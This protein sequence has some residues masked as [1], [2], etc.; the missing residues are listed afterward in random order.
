MGRKTV[1]KNSNRDK[2]IGQNMLKYRTAAGLSQAKVADYIGVERSSY[3]KYEAG[4]TEPNYETLSKIVKIL[5]TDYN[6]ILDIN[7]I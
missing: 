4:A 7:E 6:S 5:N 2:L 3:A 1:I